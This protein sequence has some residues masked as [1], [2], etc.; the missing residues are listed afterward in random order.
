MSPGHVDQGIRRPN[1]QALFSLIPKSQKAKLAVDD[2]NNSH[3][4]SMSLLNNVKSFDVGFHINS[5][6][7]T[8]TLATLGRNDC[9]IYLRPSSISRVQCSFEMDDLSSGIVMLYDQ[10]P[11]HNTRVSSLDEWGS[12]QNERSPRRVLV[13]PGFNNA[14]SMGGVHHNLIEFSL[15]WIKNEGEI[16]EAVKKHRDAAETLIIN[17]RKA[18]TRDPTITTLP[19]TKMTPL[20]PDQA[21]QR[22][23]VTP[24]RYYRQSS[25]LLGA[26]AFGTVWRAIDV[27]TGRIM[28]MKEIPRKSGSQAQVD[29][30]RVHQEVELMRRAKHVRTAAPLHTF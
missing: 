22:P 10:S 23:S 18:R 6:H 29:V 16:K 3:L 4:V 11:Q 15:E 30:N 5:S 19:S 26:G 25:K 28:A 27:D 12:F 20:S 13:Y 7:S 9:D 17:P 14:I 21:F 1:E 8:N 24:L 2:E